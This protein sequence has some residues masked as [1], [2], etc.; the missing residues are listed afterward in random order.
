MVVIVVSGLPGAGKEEFVK[1][2]VE[3]GFAVIR[4]GDVVREHARTLGLQKNDV[5]VGGYAN[6]ERERHGKD[7]WAVRTVKKLP[8]GNTIIDGCRSMYELAYFKGNIDDIITVGITASKETRFKRLASRGR[9]DDPAT[10]EDFEKREERELGWG[11]KEAVEGAMII[12]GN[13][14][15][16]EEFGE[17]CR[18]TLT[19]ISDTG[20]HAD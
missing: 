9:E 15:G 1:I 18:S 7:I 6:S 14:A 3:E 13:D 16:L 4:M 11:L 17:L 10:F 12:L 5:S 19:A 2:G 20:P 8:A